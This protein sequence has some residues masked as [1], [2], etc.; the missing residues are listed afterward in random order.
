VVVDV[1][2]FN[3]LRLGWFYSSPCEGG[4]FRVAFSLHHGKRGVVRAV[5]FSGFSSFGFPSGHLPL[6]KFLPGGSTDFF[7]L[8][9][10][11]GRAGSKK[12]KSK[13][14]AKARSRK[15]NA[16]KKTKVSS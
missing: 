8:L 4:G 14:H 11:H 5:L 6:L 9:S 12:R 3:S 16:K 7:E 13:A 1:S 15:G 2:L 10:Q